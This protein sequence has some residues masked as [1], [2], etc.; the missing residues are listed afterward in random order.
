MNNDQENLN[1]RDYFDQIVQDELAIFES[2]LQWTDRDQEEFR[3]LLDNLKQPYNKEVE[4]TKS[5]GDRLENL[6]EFIIKKSYFFEVY[7][8]VHTETNEIDEVIV[9]SS[10]GKQALKRFNLTRDLIPIDENIFLGECKN[11]E[12][13]LNV[14][15]VGK[16]YSLMTVTDISFGIIF[17]QKGLTGESESYRDANGLVKV[18]RMVEKSKNKGKEFYILSFALEDYEKLLQGTTF[19]ELV[20]AKKLEM[21]LASNYCNFLKD[22]QHDSESKIKEIISEIT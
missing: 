21:Q 17:T 8:K 12:S 16:F 19:F 10:R 14:T 3:V 7:K 6:V 2:F 22:N 15:Y 4:T 5:K 9:L 11:Y 20:K 18:L 13:N 1:L